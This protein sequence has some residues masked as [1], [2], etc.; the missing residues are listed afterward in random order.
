LDAPASLSYTVAQGLSL[1][2]GS[3]DIPYLF[4]T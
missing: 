3:G 2:C 1:A 4:L